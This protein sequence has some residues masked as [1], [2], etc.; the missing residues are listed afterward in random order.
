M[1]KHTQS[2][3]R[4]IVDIDDELFEF[5]GPFGCVGA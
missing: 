2:I 3:R 5:L 1:D 4:K